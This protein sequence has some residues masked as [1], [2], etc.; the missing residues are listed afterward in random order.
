[1]K[2]ASKTLVASFLVVCAACVSSQTQ[3]G[4]H[5]H[6]IKTRDWN[7]TWIAGNGM[8]LRVRV[9]DEVRGLL[10]CSLID[11]HEDR[12]MGQISWW[13]TSSASCGAEA[14]ANARAS[15]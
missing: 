10:E 8:T 2:C 5:P 15:F 6:S 9:L 1:M 3:V 4:G 12:R 7:G 14:T 11:E 13:S